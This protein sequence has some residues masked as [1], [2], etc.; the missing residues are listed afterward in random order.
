MWRVEWVEWVGSFLTNVLDDV[1]AVADHLRSF[2]V[3]LKSEDKQRR[4]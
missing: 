1:Q 4:I 3:A 2:S